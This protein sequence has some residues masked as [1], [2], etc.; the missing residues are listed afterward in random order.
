MSM[1]SMPRFQVLTAVNVFL[2]TTPTLAAP[3]MLAAVAGLCSVTLLLLIVYIVTLRAKNHAKRAAV[4][5][6]LGI[7]PSPNTR[8]LGFFH[9]Y[10]YVRN[11]LAYTKDSLTDS[12]NAGG[13]GERVLWTAIKAMQRNEP[14]IVSVV[15]SGDIDASKTEIIDKVLVSYG[16]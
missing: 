12:S 7:T 1:K 11:T 3:Q 6:S 9:P 15:Y 16:S 10:W 2:S 13:G 5:Q 8:L 4:F 14:D